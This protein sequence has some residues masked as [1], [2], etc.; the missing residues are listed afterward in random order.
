MQTSR[1]EGKETQDRRNDS[2]ADRMGCVVR[3]A[4]VCRGPSVAVDCMVQFLVQFN[5][6]VEA[7]SLKD[8]N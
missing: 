8:E 5:R 2:L 3:I 6:E 4:P 1:E 7:C